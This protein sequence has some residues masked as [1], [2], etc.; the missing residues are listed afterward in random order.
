MQPVIEGSAK[1]D[2]GFRILVD[3]ERIPGRTDV[4]VSAERWFRDRDLLVEHSGRVG[5]MLAPEDDP[6][7]LA[8]DVHRLDLVV[9]QFPKFT[10]G[11]AYSQARVLRVH[12]GFGGILR[13]IGDILPDQLEF[14]RRCG[15]DSFA[16]PDEPSAERALRHSRR[17]SVAYQPA[18]RGCVAGY[19]HRP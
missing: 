13:A 18:K 1:I 6:E 17:F 5:V 7:P 8:D 19:R 4:I 2:D 3:E 11:R 10:D 9:L 15:I 16:F 12:L 14:M